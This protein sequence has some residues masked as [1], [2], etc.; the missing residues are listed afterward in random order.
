MG[1]SDCFVFIAKPSGKCEVKVD[2]F[3]VASLNITL[4][5]NNILLNDFF[6]KRQG[7]IQKISGFILVLIGIL[8]IVDFF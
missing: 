2:E 8:L 4:D 6:Q 1:C 3:D 5:S 7:I